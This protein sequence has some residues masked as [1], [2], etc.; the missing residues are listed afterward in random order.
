VYSGAIVQGHTNLTDIE[1]AIE[2]LWRVDIDPSDIVMGFGFYGRSFTLADDSC[3]T[4]G[5]PF[6]AGGSP[7]PC[8]ATSGYLAYYE[9]AEVLEANPSVVPVY[10]ETAAVMYIN[11]GDNQ[12]VSYDNETTFKQKVDW[13]NGIGLGGAMIWASDQGE[14]FIA[15]ESI[16][17]ADGNNNASP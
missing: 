13:A 12:W 14:L 9:I 11:W 2:L 4:P 6:T 5:C 1:T 3:T 10:D 7:G 8:T 15:I 16:N 17:D